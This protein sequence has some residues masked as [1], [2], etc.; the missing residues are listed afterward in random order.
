[1]T[2]F[3]QVLQECLHDLEYGNASV[4]EC[5]LRHPEY[6]QQLGPILFASESL[7][8]AGQAHVSEAFKARVRARLI[9]GMYAHPRRSAR[10][11][12]IFVRLA[13]SFAVVLLA[14]LV[15]GTAYAQSTLPGNMFYGWKLAS[16]NAWRAVSTDPVETDLQI[17]ERRVNELV[18]VRDDP[19]LRSQTLQEYFETVNRLRSQT[20]PEDDL[21]I[22]QTLDSQIAKLKKLGIL[23]SQVDPASLPS[24]EPVPPT[25]MLQGVTPTAQTPSKLTPTIE[26][27]PAINP[28]V[29][30]PPAGIPTIEIPPELIPTFEIPP[31]IR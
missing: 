4:D 11:G 24:D 9:E 19:E 2:E 1:M 12:L 26:I 27:P 21:R 3:E 16:E 8:R 6:S 22:V 18:A 10:S 31:P 7:G 14:L 20:D 29:E 30:F 15:T 17:A 13:V 23:L 25:P 28:T 5:L